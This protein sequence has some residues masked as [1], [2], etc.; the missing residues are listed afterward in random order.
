MTKGGKNL[1]VWE[2]RISLCYKNVK[3][4]YFFL[5]AKIYSFFILKDRHTHK[6]TT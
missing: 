1:L 3:D 2:E 5:Q 6:H 4:N